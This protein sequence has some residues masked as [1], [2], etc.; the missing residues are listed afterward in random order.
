MTKAEWEAEGERRFGKDMMRWR[1]VCPSCGHIASVQDYKDAGAP[2]GA[3]AFSCVG[4]WAGAGDENTFKKAG[5]PCNY[6]GGGLIGLNP[7][8]VGDGRYFDFA[9]QE[10][11]PND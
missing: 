1:F 5:G 10:E 4:R 2:V 3:I 9:P 6:A 7:L 11:V 8:E